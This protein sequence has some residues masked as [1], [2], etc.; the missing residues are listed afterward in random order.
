MEEKIMHAALPVI[1]ISELRY[2]P[3][4]VLEQ[5]KEQPVILAQRSKGVAVLM[6][7]E[8]Y[9]RLVSRLEELLD[10]RDELVIALYRARQGEWRLVDGEQL[11]ALYQE[12]E[13]EEPPVTL[14]P[15][16]S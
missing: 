11:L 15:T 14:S 1:P 6:D 7:L 8:T 13:G 5:V 4:R 16:D 12:R 2:H 9:N 3:R 10:L